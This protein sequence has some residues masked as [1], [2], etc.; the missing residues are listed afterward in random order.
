MYLKLDYFHLLF[1]GKHTNPYKF[2]IQS[3]T[4]DQV[5]F[6]DA[7]VVQALGKIIK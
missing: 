3:R 1:L 2:F 6:S 5:Q 7:L 4:L